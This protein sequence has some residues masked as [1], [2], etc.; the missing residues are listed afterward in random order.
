MI[1][2][3]SIEN[4][5]SI[6]KKQVLSFEATKDNTSRELLTIEV[7]ST[8]R[9]NRMLILYGA[10]ASGKSN[11]LYAYETIWRMLVLPCTHKLQAIPFHPFAL[12]KDKNT[13]LS[14]SFFIEQVRYDYSLEYN[15][16]HIISEK[17]EYAPN[18]VL[19]LFYNRKFVHEDVV[20]DIE[21]GRTVGLHLKSKKTIIDNTLNNHTVLSTFAKISLSEDAKIFRDTY[22]WIVRYVHGMKG[23]TLLD[24]AQQLI[25]DKEKKDYFISAM[26]K[27]DF[28]ISNISLRICSDV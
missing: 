4:F 27:A 19:S 1:R 8:V 26:Q 17:M 23:N 22:N 5:M 16:H 15:N 9:L 20:P 6:R 14:V 28:N 18:G 12:D 2:E 25:N 10:N 7:K 3:L 21:F 11:I 13:R 24:I